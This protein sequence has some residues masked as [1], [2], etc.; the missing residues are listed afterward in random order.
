MLKKWVDALTKSSKELEGLSETLDALKS[1]DYL[2][3][4]KPGDSMIGQQLIELQKLRDEFSQYRA[5]EATYRAAEEHR[6]KVAERKGFL[7]GVVATLIVTIIANLFIY[8]W[9]S[10]VSLFANVFQ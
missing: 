5:D 6:A 1:G 10:I 3:D 2:A 7:R 4:V 9:P 8:Y